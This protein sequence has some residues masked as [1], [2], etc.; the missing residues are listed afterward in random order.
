[1]TRN[2][3]LKVLQL[4]SPAGL[5]GAERWILALIKHLDPKQVK[6]IVGVIRD[7]SIEDV[8]L[9]T[10]AEKLGFAT[11]I[12][13]AQGR[14]NFSA[15]R[16]LKKYIIEKQIDILHTHFYK[17]D[18]IGF[19]ATRG[20]NCKLVSTPHG[21]STKADFKLWCYEQLDRLIFPFMDAVVPLSE[22]LYIPL[23]ARDRLFRRS[24]ATSN[25]QLINNGVDLSEVEECTTVAEELQGWRDQ[26]EFII[27]YI[28][29]LIPRKG[30]DVLLNALSKLGIE[31]SWR[32]ALVG[33]GE[34]RTELE[35]IV[36][37]LGLR[38]RVSFFGY[39][40]NRLE[41]LRGFDVFV[42]PSRLEGI[43]RC[44]MEAMA[45]EKLVL[46]SDI[47]G[48]NDL[49]AHQK[50]GLLFPLGNSD[51]LCGQLRKI[52]G[53]PDEMKM[54][55]KNGYVDVKSNYSATRMAVEYH[56]LYNH[57]DLK[58]FHKNDSF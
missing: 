21:W 33:E 46:A 22:D 52:Y 2:K 10:E 23:A 51:E 40:E 26:G 58:H 15:V 25:V 32:L 45:A 50:N 8:P 57:I 17:T 31:P 3:P 39:R 6:T 1:M 49:I 54:L 37:Q 34:Q 36:E 19:W 41:F 20:T 55:A 29:Q 30:L 14:F 38:E 35:K 7:S 27:G 9:C 48:C 42:L 5:Y 44:L 43:P 11:A 28:G 13:E 56:G 18:L 4:G 24:K 12:I 16:K 47:P 53:D